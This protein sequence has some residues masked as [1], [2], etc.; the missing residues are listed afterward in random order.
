M[1]WSREFLWQEGHTAH[2]SLDEAAL[3]VRQA[4]ISVY[5]IFSLFVPACPG[6]AAP[7]PCC[8]RELV[9]S[10]DEVLCIIKGGVKQ[11]LDLYA[12]VYQDLLAVPVIQGNK[13][14]NEK[15]PRTVLASSVTSVSATE[16]QYS[17]RGSAPVPVTG[18]G[19]SR[20]ICCYWIPYPFF[21]HSVTMLRCSAD[22]ILVAVAWWDPEAP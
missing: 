11:V 21:A 9:Q 13:T 20:R 18:F 12:E 19:P 3:E 10:T 14:A 4:R 5:R 2:A 7:S 17:T 6:P 8:T 15:V 22:S 1:I 16:W